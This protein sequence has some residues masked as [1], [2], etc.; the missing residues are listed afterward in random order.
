MKRKIEKIKERATFTEGDYNLILIIDWD[1]REWTITTDR[2][3]QFTFKNTINKDAAVIIGNLI[4]KASEF[5]F[6]RLKITDAEI[7]DRKDTIPF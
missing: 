7:K 4:S 6:D 2:G 5:A 3:E 1:K